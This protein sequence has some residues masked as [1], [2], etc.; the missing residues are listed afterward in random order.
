MIKM[1]CKY[2]AGVGSVPLGLSENCMLITKVRPVM[3]VD[4]SEK[5]VILEFVCSHVCIL[6]L[7]NVEL[8]SNCNIHWTS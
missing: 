5:E 7:K 8:S 2:A 3:L 1:L 6:L 4:S